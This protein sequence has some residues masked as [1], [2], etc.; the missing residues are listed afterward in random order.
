MKAIIV[1]IKGKH[2]AVL[3]D[4]GV[5]SKVKNRNFCLGQEIVIRKNSNNFIKMV[6][7]AAAA[8]MIFVTPAW[9]YLTPY[10]YVSIDVNPSF[11]FSINRFDRVLTVKAI[12]DDGRE[13][14]KDINIDSLKNKEIQNAVKSVLGELKNRGYIIEGE[15]G[16]IVAASSKTQDKT[17]M[18]S[19]KLR[20]AVK[21]EVGKKQKAE[22]TGETE[23]KTTESPEEPVKTKKPEEPENI[24]KPSKI[25]D[26]ETNKESETLRENEDFTDNENTENTDK[27][28]KP[29]RSDKSEKPEK[30]DKHDKSDKTEKQEKTE[31]SD[32]AEK[33]EKQDK[34]ERPDK[35][36]RSDRPDKPEKPE[37]SEKSRT[38]QSKKQKEKI[39]VKVIEVTKKEVD[40]AKKLGVT[41]GKL[42]LV[43]K[44]CETAK[45]A[46]HK[47]EADEWFNK[48]VQEINEKT[49]EY[50]EEAKQKENK[51]NKKDSDKRNSEDRNDKERDSRDKE[52]DSRDNDSKKKKH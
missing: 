36:D 13:L 46:G 39:N 33:Q 48:S 27:P 10:S 6:A 8:V 51:N 25:Q 9:A 24:E 3:S 5:V 17:D 41:P 21:E 14:S 15:S 50:K 43:E 7:S 26:T 11:E 12:N 30:P 35:P 22:E 34:T 23:V 45:S 4:D 47:I 37:K 52:R 2:V 18:L 16:V 1:E 31:R 32:K 38:D 40:E 19:E 20:T 29:K 28:E 42:N 49:K 44:L